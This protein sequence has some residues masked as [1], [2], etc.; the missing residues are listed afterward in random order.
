MT[1]GSPKNVPRTFHNVGTVE[2]K[3][4]VVAVPAGAFKLLRSCRSPSTQ[5][6]R[7]TTPPD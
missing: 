2:A 1:M 7:H 5:C 6:N 4:M 3:M